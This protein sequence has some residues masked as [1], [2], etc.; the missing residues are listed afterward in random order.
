M[1]GKLG[2][3][4]AKTDLKLS[5]AYS[6]NQLFGNGLQ[7]TRLLAA[8]YSSVYTKPD[9]TSNRS[10]ML[11]LA[12]QHSFRD[13]LVFSGNAYYRELKTRTLNGDGNEASLDQSVYQ[14]SAAEGA[15]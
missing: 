1:F 13:D 10:M 14:P 12:G 6:N 2:W 11:N 3:R 7:E 8:D 9:I 5:A 4:N 15:H